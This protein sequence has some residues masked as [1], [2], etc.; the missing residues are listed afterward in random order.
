MTAEPR[1]HRSTAAP[2]DRLRARSDRAGFQGLERG[3]WV[4]ISSEAGGTGARGQRH[5]PAAQH[6]VTARGVDAGAWHSSQSLG[7]VL[8]GQSHPT[9][10]DGIAVAFTRPAGP[11]FVLLFS[12]GVHRRPLVP[13]LHVEPRGA[14]RECQM[15]FPPS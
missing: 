13:P 5:L 3:R 9:R 1:S 6:P 15:R 4:I 2:R 11:T 10:A 14:P 12:Y 7:K 8:A